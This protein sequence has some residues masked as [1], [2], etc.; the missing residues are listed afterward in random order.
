M[1]VRLFGCV[2]LALLMTVHSAGC[3]SAGQ[4][5]SASKPPSRSRTGT[6]VIPAREAVANNS[7][8][9]NGKESSKP[10][11]SSDNSN[12]ESIAAFPVIQ[13]KKHNAVAV[14]ARSGG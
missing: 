7:N 4:S 10:V 11:E 8:S 1:F 14:N 2:V 6:Q 9:A 5:Q 13:E 12:G 3:Q